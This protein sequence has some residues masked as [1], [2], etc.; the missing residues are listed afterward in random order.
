MLALVVL[1]AAVFAGQFLVD[2]PSTVGDPYGSALTT[3]AHAAPSGC[4]NR[5][6]ADS[7]G[8]S[9]GQAMHENLV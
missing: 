8:S 9:W 2:T 4:E 3:V 7:S 6:F 5:V 1:P